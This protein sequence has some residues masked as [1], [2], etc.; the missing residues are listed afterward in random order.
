M[1]VSKASQAKRHGKM[2]TIQCF[3]NFGGVLVV[4]GA[5]GASHFC[6]QAHALSA[7]SLSEKRL[8]GAS[9][10]DVAQQGESCSN[11]AWY[12]KCKTESPR[13]YCCSTIRYD[14]PNCVCD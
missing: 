10:L 9:R 8:S 13:D 4:A 7:E 11:Y 1:A 6:G 3:R 12:R 5:L 2:N 14:V